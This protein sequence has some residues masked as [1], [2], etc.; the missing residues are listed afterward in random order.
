MISAFGVLER[1]NTPP[2]DTNASPADMMFKWK[3]LS[4]LP[5]VNHRVTD[6]DA[7]V[8]SEPDERR[9]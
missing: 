8:H 5:T 7:A 4:H 1:R 3:L 9:L 2:Q 6:Y